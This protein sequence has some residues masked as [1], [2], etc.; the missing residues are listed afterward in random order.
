[1]EQAN[2]SQGKAAGEDCLR[3]AENE[4]LRSSGPVE[5][6]PQACQKR[7]TNAREKIRG[8]IPSR[9]GE[10]APIFHFRSVR[11]KRIIAWR[12]VIEGLVFGNDFFQLGFDGRSILFPGQVDEFFNPLV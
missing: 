5:S 10:C 6:I 1:M 3:D 12:F 9:P 8:Q 7:Q 2:D 4:I 11:G